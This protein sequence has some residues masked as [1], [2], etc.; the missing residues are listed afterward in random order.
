[1]SSHSEGRYTLCSPLHHWGLPQYLFRMRYFGYNMGKL[2]YY[3]SKIVGSVGR[4]RLPLS[5][6]IVEG[7]T[8][9]I[10]VLVVCRSGVNGS[11][12]RQ[13]LLIV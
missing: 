7:L 5:I 6:P 13:I 12:C 4:G 9:L 3:A 2:S 11:R 1:M 8:N 10:N